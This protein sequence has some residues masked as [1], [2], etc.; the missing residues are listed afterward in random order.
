MKE[1]ISDLKLDTINWISFKPIEDIIDSMTSSYLMMFDSL[2]AATIA[3]YLREEI[4]KTHV[5]EAVIAF[6]DIEIFDLN[7]KY[8]LAELEI[9]GPYDFDIYMMV[10]GNRDQDWNFWYENSKKCKNVLELCYDRGWFP[11]DRYFTKTETE[12]AGGLI[13]LGYSNHSYRRYSIYKRST[14]IESSV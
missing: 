10:G 9:D 5:L 13:N 8:G 7:D 2:Y 12:E 4:E 1:Y 3:D 11:H 6:P 14:Q